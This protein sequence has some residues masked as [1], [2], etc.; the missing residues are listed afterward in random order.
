MGK[1]PLLQSGH[2]HHRKLEPLGVV[3]GEH[4]HPVRALADEIGIAHQRGLGEEVP[5]GAAARRRE[6]GGSVAQ[7]FHIGLALGGILV[8]R[9][10]VQVPDALQEVGKQHVDRHVEPF[11]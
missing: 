11:S 1:Q 9:Q 4:E 3:G 10:I 6:A 2:D 5:Q 7:L 8:A